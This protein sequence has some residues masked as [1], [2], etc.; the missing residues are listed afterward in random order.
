M[1]IYLISDSGMFK[2][3]K[4]TSYGRNHQVVFE[5]SQLFDTFFIRSTIPQD[6]QIIFTDDAGFNLVV[7]I[8]GWSGEESVKGVPLK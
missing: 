3:K 5:N 4:H 7:T 8:G 6:M 2:L 1:N